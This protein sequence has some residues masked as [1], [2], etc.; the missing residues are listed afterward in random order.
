MRHLP[1]C[2][3]CNGKERGLLPT[4]PS[5][6]GGLRSA[7]HQTDWL[8]TGLPR[9]GISTCYVR[10]AVF[11]SPAR[12]V[13]EV[14]VALEERQLS[15]TRHLLQ[16][17]PYAVQ[18]PATASTPC[19]PAGPAAREGRVHLPSKLLRA[20]PFQVPRHRGSGGPH[21]ITEPVPFG[22]QPTAQQKRP[23]PLL[24]TNM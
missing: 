10:F 6:V 7:R 22:A 19:P 20:Q 18:Q 5:T 23:Q 14:E 8:N 21:H 9:K 17:L 3:I 11:S 12:R 4:V 13:G 2:A 16:Q 15:G 24:L 1:A